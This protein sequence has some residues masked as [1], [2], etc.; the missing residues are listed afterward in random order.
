MLPGSFS[1]LH[2]TPFS[3][4]QASLSDKTHSKTWLFTGHILFSNWQTSVG[5]K[6]TKGNSLSLESTKNLLVF[7]LM[8]G[9]S[10][11]RRGI[12]WRWGVCI[13]PGAQERTE[14]V[15]S[16]ADSDSERKWNCWET[17]HL[18]QVEQERSF[19]L[20]ISLWRKMAHLVQAWD[21]VSWAGGW[22]RG[23]RKWA[24]EVSGAFKAT[25]S[26]SFWNIGNVNFRAQA[27][28]ANLN[29]LPWELMT[30]ANSLRLIAWKGSESSCFVK[31]R[32]RPS[33][34]FTQACSFSLIVGTRYFFKGTQEEMVK[35]NK[36]L[37]MSFQREMKRRVVFSPSLLRWNVCCGNFKV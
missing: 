18:Y 20:K 31:Y 8:G 16:E 1:F 33:D 3:P 7:S 17:T 30:S 2:P 29:F 12:T 4:P 14:A 6:F 34:F 13:P 36:E 9:G 21:L 26:C 25:S 22:D 15:L 35:T 5:W 32:E 28:L 19:F 37:T 27:W 24:W 11:T 23:T 10:W